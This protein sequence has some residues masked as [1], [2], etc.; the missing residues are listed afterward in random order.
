MCIKF[1]N[2]ILSVFLQRMIFKSILSNLFHAN[3]GCSKAQLTGA[4]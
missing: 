2:W 4:Q 3:Q 1:E